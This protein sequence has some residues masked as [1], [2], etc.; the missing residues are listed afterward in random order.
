MD[1]DLGEASVIALTLEIENSILLIDD[2]KARKISKRLNLKYS[3]TFG[4]I[5]RAKQEGIIKHI[6]PVL[7]KIRNTDFRFSDKLFD[8]I[9]EQAGE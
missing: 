5:L 4:L 8:I 9:L 1:L 7:G 3:G 6:K 2:L